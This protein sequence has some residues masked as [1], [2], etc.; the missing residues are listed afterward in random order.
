MNELIPRERQAAGRK[1]SVTARAWISRPNA[2]AKFVSRVSL[3]K[4]RCSSRNTETK[5]RAKALEFNRLH[6]IELLMQPKS[7]PA[8]L[9]AQQVELFGSG[10]LPC[11]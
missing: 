5:N 4:G 3:G 2:R 9:A 6:L 8:A 7:R 10:S 11:P 1:Q